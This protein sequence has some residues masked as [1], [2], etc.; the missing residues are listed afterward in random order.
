[1]R[2][3]IVRTFPLF[4]LVLAS[5]EVSAQSASG[6]S[7]SYFI[8]ALI[9]L[10][11]VIFLYMIIQVADN[12]LA[13]E[14]RN[15]KSEKEGVNLGLFPGVKEI[16]ASKAPDYVGDAPVTV[17]RKGHNILLEGEA[18][19]T[20]EAATGVNTYAIQPPNFRGILPIPKV[21]VEA[22]QHVNAGD[23]LF[24]D[25]TKP[26]IK[27]VSP[28]SGEVIAINRAEKRAIAEVV[29]LADKTISYR[30][31]E[32]PD[33]QS[34]PRETLVNFLMASGAW[35][36]LRQRPFDVLAEPGIVPRDIFISTF[37]T[38][39]LAPDLN[40]VVEGKGV[41]F[42]KGLDVLAK[43]TSGEVHLGLDA[44]GSKAPS[45]VFTGATG[46]QKHW[47]SG[48]HPAGNVGIQIHHIK[49]INPNEKVWTL[50]VQDVITIG[51]L[52]VEG[53]FNASRVV[54]LTGAE[55]HS[56][57]YVQTFMG[58]NMGEL[59]SGN[60][61][62]GNIR[63]VSGDVLSGSKKSAGQFLNASDD[64]VTAI[65]EG[66]YFEMFGWLLPLTLRPSVSKTFPNFLFPGY[67]F[68]ADTNTHGE[69]RAFVVTGQY[70][71]VLP[72]DIFPQHLFKAI[73]VND[74]ERMEGLGIFEV[75][76]EDVALCEFVC[77]SKQPLQEILR[78][79]L[80][81]MREEA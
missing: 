19:C 68:R 30:T 23:E 43:L 10:A 66:D 37:D 48:K 60:L 36:L 27:F 77:T 11:I 70:E 53:R 29:I 26:E 2:S 58:A 5:N 33:L 54:A 9:A 25:K 35:P 61:K 47:F 44:H 22:G 41:L 62:E 73:I 74:I 17:L 4:F 75:T 20:L 18:A 6:G 79:G 59:V 42:Q 65:G 8:Y 46:V 24:H 34:S 78:D 76:E 39:P 63:L 45:A 14:A 56:P 69:K 32:A 51:A 81:T 50:N 12:M 49:P 57:K 3:G 28:V 67:K 80:D 64:Q 15:S 72:M 71:E 16:F 31:I 40:F 52:F 38:A 21:V 55:L 1:M 13:I 7:S